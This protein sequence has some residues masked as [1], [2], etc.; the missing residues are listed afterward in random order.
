M[1]TIDDKFDLLSKDGKEINKYD[2]KTFA[3]VFEFAR[4]LSEIDPTTREGLEKYEALTG[5]ST[6]DEFKNEA[7]LGYKKHNAY[8]N[9]LFGEYLQRNID[10]VTNELDDNLVSGI[11]YEFCPDISSKD[12]SDEEYNTAR[13]AI[14]NAKE[15]IKEIEEKPKEY[16]ERQIERAEENHMKKI[17]ALFPEETLKIDK[18]SSER[19]ARIAIQEYGAKRFVSGIYTDLKSLEKEVEEESGELQK[20]AEK[21]EREMPLKYNAKQEADYTAEIREKEEALSEKAKNLET[22][23][24]LT[25]TIAQYAYRTIED[26]KE[27]EKKKK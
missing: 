22:I 13:E 14:G 6:E 20:E 21:L 15:T 7:K 23:P 3:D 27:E 8:L 10:S 17:I 19:K 26:K 11:A 12:S 1:A 4:S 9:N 18:E 16:F 24:K 5:R 25:G 2:P